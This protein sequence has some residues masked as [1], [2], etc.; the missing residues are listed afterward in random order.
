MDKQAKPVLRYFLTCAGFLILAE[1]SPFEV[2]DRFYR[3][4]RAHAFLPAFYAALF[5]VGAALGVPRHASW[6]QDAMRGAAC[7]FLSG[8]LAQATVLVVNGHTEVALQNG[9]ASELGSSFLMGTVVFATP[10]WGAVCA[11]VDKSL[12]S[13]SIFP[14]PAENGANG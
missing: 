13:K 3:F 6:R 12:A 9:G 5:L 7:G 10:V 8:V 11:L 1:L 4:D 2:V 14:G